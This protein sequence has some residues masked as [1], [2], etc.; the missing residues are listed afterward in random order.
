MELINDSPKIGEEITIIVS[1]HNIGNVTAIKV[2]TALYINNKFFE[3]KTEYS[4]L[5]DEKRELKFKWKTEK[6]S[7]EFLVRIDEK[8]AIMEANESNNNASRTLNVLSEIPTFGESRSK[9]RFILFQFLLYNIFILPILNLVFLIL[10]IFLQKK[11]KIKSKKNKAGLILIIFGLIIGILLIFFSMFIAK[12][13]S[14]FE[15][16]AKSPNIKAG[17]KITLAGKIYSVNETTI[18]GKSFLEIVVCAECGK[19]V[20]I[21]H[22]EKSVICECGNYLF[23]F[24]KEFL[25]N[26]KMTNKVSIQTGLKKNGSKKFLSNLLNNI[27]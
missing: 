16:W 23:I 22:G 19:S 7:H 12:S 1:I 3:N 10:G 26:M 20:L 15:E 21:C 25:K 8:N 11:P 9:E 18:D 13:P 27:A 6:G 14:Q 4:I 2:E 17:D 5:P 24:S